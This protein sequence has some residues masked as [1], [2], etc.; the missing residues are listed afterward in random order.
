MAPWTRIFTRIF[1]EVFKDY[2]GRFARCNLLVM[3]IYLFLPC[4]VRGEPL[5]ARGGNTNP[6]PVSS[7]APFAVGVSNIKKMN[8]DEVMANSLLDPN[9]TKCGQDCIYQKGNEVIS[10]QLD[11]MIGKK[12][13][14]ERP[15]T[16]PKQKREVLGGFCP[17]KTAQANPPNSNPQL[18]ENG[19]PILDEDKDQDD[20]DE[21]EEEVKQ[22]VDRYKQI[23][24]F[25]LLKTR[26]ALGKNH[27]SIADLSCVKWENGACTARVTS[28]VAHIQV[29]ELENKKA[30]HSTYYTKAKDLAMLRE[31]IQFVP[32]DNK[33]WENTFVNALKPSKDDF[34]KF[35]KIPR[36]PDNPSAGDLQVPVYKPDGSLEYDE[37]AYQRA[38]A[39]WGRL[40]GEVSS[41]IQGHQVNDIMKQN[42]EKFIRDFKFEGRK[43][44]KSEER[45]NFDFE[46][47]AR[48]QQFQDFSDWARTTSQKEMT[49][50]GKSRP[51]GLPSGG[52]TYNPIREPDGGFTGNEDL[53]PNP[54]PQG[55]NRVHIYTESSGAQIGV[56]AR[57]N[58]TPPATPPNPSQPVQIPKP[59]IKDAP[60]V[61]SERNPSGVA[62]GS[63]TDP[64]S[65]LQRVIDLY[66]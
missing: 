8:P 56:F 2:W 44:Q 11:Y 48:V 45:K 61:G 24:A 20:D 36:D 29:D 65:D 52:P 13:F 27:K 47:G 25:W 15:S 6:G 14:L 64:N 26:G 53:K 59:K 22:C 32:I 37:A 66:F 57:P 31:Q 42:R 4:V 21:D 41:M 43:E 18:D 49:F 46:R 58:S 50:R 1:E 63:A 3:L 7:A 60:P 12:D 40:N 39:S 19:Q 30:D 33:T 17:K 10:Q 35:K 16:T 28:P 9:F 23:V 55:R 5:T 62:P 38:K 34:V 54:Q 51:S